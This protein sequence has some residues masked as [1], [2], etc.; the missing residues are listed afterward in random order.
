MEDGYEVL[1]DGY[2]TTDAGSATSTDQRLRRIEITNPGAGYQRLPSVFPGG[3][4]YFE[5]ITDGGLDPTPSDFQEGEGVTGETSNATGTILRLDIPNNRLVI[6]RSSSDTGVFQVGE[7][8]TG[9]NTN[10]EKTLRTFPG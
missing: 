9:S 8:V 1:L 6:K 3:Y 2:K 7:T 5:S 4:L 10:I